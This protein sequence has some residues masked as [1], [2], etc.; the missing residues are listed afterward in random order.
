MSGGAKLAINMAKF[1]ARMLAI[2]LIAGC[3]TSVREALR[4]AQVSAVASLPQPDEL[5]AHSNTQDLVNRIELGEG[6]RVT[7]N[8]ITP[9]SSIGWNSYFA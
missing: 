4:R 6:T 3:W 5:F 8:P 1:I 7:S 9:A 2:M